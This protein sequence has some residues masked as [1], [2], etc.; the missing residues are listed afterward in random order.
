M[1]IRVGSNVI[2]G[3]GAGLPS[4]TGQ[5]GKYLTTDGTDASWATLNVDADGKSITRNTDDQLQTVG[6]INQ[7][8]TTTA[9]KT[10][11]GTKAQYDAIVTKDANTLYNITDDA[12]P[13]S[14]VYS[15]AEVDSLIDTKA[16]VS[17]NNVNS[18]GQ[19]NLI[20]YV[21]SN[22][23]TTDNTKVGYLYIVD[24]GSASVYAPSGGKWLVLR[25]EQ[26]SDSTAAKYSFASGTFGKYTGTIVDG[27][28]QV[29]VYSSQVSGAS[30]KIYVTLLK[31]V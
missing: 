30:C 29:A 5:S 23:Q 16:N 26:I 20:Q 28:E 15:K 6:I 8:D 24:G 10:W 3:G 13:S 22:L 18:T 14:T 17:L 21:L 1:T 27:G 2:A 9:L 25:N 4:Q 19:Y 7:N 11:S 31:I 12:S